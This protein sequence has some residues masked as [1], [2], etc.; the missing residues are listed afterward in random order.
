MR[1]THFPRWAN[2][3]Y[4]LPQISHLIFSGFNSE[5]SKYP[6]DTIS[7]ILTWMRTPQVPTFTICGSFQLM[8]YAH[9]AEIAPIGTLPKTSAPNLDPILP[10][11]MKAELGFQSITSHQPSQLFDHEKPCWTIFQHH[12]WE[13]KNIPDNFRHTA[14]SPACSIQA[15]EH[16]TL[17]LSGVQFHPEDY[18]TAYPD[19]KTILSNVFNKK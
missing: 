9:G 14:I 16:K 18:D 2:G 15:L 3:D 7:D 11:D 12:Y 17:P 4:P 19:G 6:Q 5:I 10:N 8:A 1:Y 13:V